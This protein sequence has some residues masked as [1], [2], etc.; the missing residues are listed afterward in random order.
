MLHQVAFLTCLDTA[1]TVLLMQETWV[2]V[3]QGWGTTTAWDALLV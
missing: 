3:V 2:R 1:S